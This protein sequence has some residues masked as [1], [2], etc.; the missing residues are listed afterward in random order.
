LFQ[1]VKQDFVPLA[2]EC[3]EQARARAPQ[4]AGTLALRL[5]AISDEQL[6]AV[7]EAVEPSGNNSVLDPLL[8]ECARES[9]FSLTLPPTL[10]TGRKVFEIRMRVGTEPAPDAPP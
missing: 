10:V 4:L 3:I 7:I 5:E 1:A 2:R 8:L 6:G 9:A